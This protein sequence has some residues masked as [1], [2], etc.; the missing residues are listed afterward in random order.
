MKSS[1]IV[2]SW[3][4]VALI[5]ASAPSLAKRVLGY[6]P[7]R[8]GMPI[9]QA[10]KK[11]AGSEGLKRCE[12][13]QKELS[14][15]LEYMERGAI[16]QKV[17]IFFR[18]NKAHLIRLIPQVEKLKLGQELCGRLYMAM[19]QAIEAT[20]GPPD[21]AEQVE[22]HGSLISRS[23]WLDEGRHMRISG[24]WMKAARFCTGVTIDFRDEAYQSG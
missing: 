14:G 18:D 10:E 6:D 13:M 5:C 12:A 22:K 24:S 3:L 15:C 23:V 4:G 7:V 2:G 17:V 11:L 8:L 16:D 21:I 9:E 20:Y 19:R 1:M